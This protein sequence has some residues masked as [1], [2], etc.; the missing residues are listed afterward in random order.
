M[1]PTLIF[2]DFH[3]LFQ[4]IQFRLH[5][6]AASHSWGHFKV[7]NGSSK[8]VGLGVSGLWAV[9]V[10]GLEVSKSS[11]SNF[12][13]GGLAVSQSLEFTM[14]YPYSTNQLFR[15]IFSQISPPILPCFASFGCLYQLYIQGFQNYH[16]SY[17]SA[18]NII[19]QC[20]VNH[21]KYLN[22]LLFLFLL[23]LLYC[24]YIT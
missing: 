23:L 10:I 20:H 16:C 12:E 21:W 11:V 18:K 3:I 13:T 2:L 8:N 15:I 19:S 6:T 14:L 7:Q 9:F 17:H 22:K 24:Q 4:Q 1:V 5:W